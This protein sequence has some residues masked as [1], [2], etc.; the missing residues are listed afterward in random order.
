MEKVIL[1]KFGEIWLKGRN[2][3]VFV[4]HLVDNISA[5]TGAEK[6]DI[7]AE[8]GRIYVN[9]NHDN[10]KIFKNLSTVFGI[11]GFVEAAKLPIDYEA[12]KEEVLKLTKNAKG[13]FRISTRRSMK[14]FEKNSEE[15]NEEI[16]EKVLE[17]NKNL[18]VDLENPDLEIFIEVRREGIFL[19]TDKDEKE[20]PGGLPVGVSGKGLLML[21]GGIDSPVAGW[22]MMKRGMPVD[23]V[24]FHS[25]PYTGDKTKEKILD[26]AKE[27]SK[28]RPEPVTVYV[29]YFTEIQEKTSKETPDPLLTLIHRRY[30]RYIAEEIAEKNG[31]KALI[32]GENVGQVS[33]Q[34]VEN[35]AAVSEGAK[36][37]I[38]RPVLGNDKEETIRLAKEIDTYRL[39]ILPYEDCCT[40][41]ASENPAIK[42]KTEDLL[43]VEENFDTENLIKNALD[44]MEVYEVK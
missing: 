9:F 1:I 6:K 44:K 16:G 29:P 42:T 33:S 30:M 35:I 15:I 43:E 20:G 4:D 32:T 37:P 34:T 11:T 39:S 26:L 21:S 13:S 19:Y 38:F 18:K 2:R 28:W 17:Q 3:S 23:A 14:K 36:Y 31:Y 8:E 24:Y 40:T 7:A 27:L 41:F 22:H 5:I 12:L 10:D 25:P